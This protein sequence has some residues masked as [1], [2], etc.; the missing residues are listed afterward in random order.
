M[1]QRTG[2]RIN[3]NQGLDTKTDP[4]QVA[5]GRFLSL[6]NSVFTKTGR[7]QKRN[8]YGNLPSLISSASYATTFNGDL[9]AIGSTLQALPTNSTKWYSKGSLQPASLSVLPIIRNNLNQTQADSAIA[10]NGFVCTV[11]SETDGTTISY[12]YVVADSTTGQNIIAPTALAADPVLGTPKVFLLGFYFVIVYTNHP[13]AYNLKYIAVS[14]NDPSIVTAPATISTS[15][16]PSASIAFDGAVLGNSLYLAWNGAAASGVKMAFLTSTLS[17]SST[18]NPDPSH[19]ATIMSV[20]VDQTNSTIWASYYDSGTSNGYSIAVSPQLALLASFPAHIITTGTI[21][22]IASAAQSGVA[23][24]FYETSHTDNGVQTNFVSYVTVTQSNAAVSAAVVS[25]RSVGLASKAFIINGIIYYFCA[26]S[27]PFQPTYFLV[28]GTLSTS[29]LPNILGKLAYENGGGYLATGVPSV[30]VDGTRLSVPYLFKD[31]VQALNNSNAAGTTVTNSVYSQ[32]GINL[33]TFDLTSDGIVSAEIGSNLNIT[34]GLTWAYDGY[35]I[36]EQGFNVWPEPILNTANTT[37]GGHMTAQIYFYVATYEWTDNQGNAFRSAP[38]VP[39][40]VDRSGTGTSTC[41]SSITIPTLRL[42]SKTSNP[43]KIVLY[44]WSTANQTF[45]QT[46]SITAPTLNS[47]TVD[48]VTIVD[49]NADTS[50]VGNNILYTTGGVIENIGPPSFKSMW[51]FDDRMWGIDSE[52]DNLLWN[53]KQVIEATPVEMS[54]LL[55]V[56]VAPN[57]GAQGPSGGLKCGSPMDDKNVLF[58]ASSILYFNGTGPDNTG[59]NSQYSQPVLITST[60]GCSNQKSVV[61]MPQGLMFE[62]QSEAGNQ[63][64][65]LG[66]DLATKYIGADV[67]GL[68][69]N[70][71]VQS[72]V[73]IPGTNQVRFTLSSGIT[74]IYDYYQ[75]Q[76]GSF[77]NVPAVS[78]TL[79]QGLHTYIDQYGKVFQETPGLYLDG[80]SPVLMSFVTSWISL[81]GISGYERIYDLYIL[82]QYF[83]PHDLIVDM[84]YDFNPSTSHRVDIDPNPTNFSSAVPSS[85]GIPTPAGAPGDIEQW[86]V[87]AKRQLCQSFQISV[88]EVFNASYGATAGAGFALSGLNCRIGIKKGARPI[89]GASSAG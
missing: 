19:Q 13:S 11:Y 48:S 35:S 32:T 26:Y 9:T 3:F 77:V 36:V 38:G 20:C 70:A 42:T 6:E 30:S 87:H 61:F 65:L 82:G 17:L 81:A 49:D 75:G 72:A 50:I 41:T 47:T 21:L 85:F 46:T 56:Y 28:N 18:T 34:G 45:Y 40:E 84:A 79:Y 57:I 43:V 52:D 16:T 53:S 67:E 76:W 14:V 58:K 63:I 83:S 31:L 71:T 54:D 68:T 24:V 29:A 55:T 2:L 22:N 4:F 73:N 1:I 62:F 64:W 89:P 10:P 59:A 25:L 39:I 27:S 60:V 86:R 37:T 12:K 74:L 51:L 44:R 88:Q 66:R 80:S 23:T 69:Q 33:A 8:G 78:S 15:Y 7:L 5:P